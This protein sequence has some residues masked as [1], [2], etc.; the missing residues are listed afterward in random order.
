MDILKVSQWQK[1][2]ENK[3]KK[4]LLALFIVLSPTLASASIF[5]SDAQ[6]VGIRNETGTDNLN[7]LLLATSTIGNGT[8]TILAIAVQQQSA[9]ESTVYCGSNATGTAEAIFDSMISTNTSFQRFMQFKCNKAIYVDNYRTSFLGM[10]YVDRD[11]ATT[12]DPLVLTPQ[13]VTGATST[14]SVG[15]IIATYDGA[16]FQETLFIACVIIF[17]L[18]IL[19]WP[20]FFRM[21][22]RQDPI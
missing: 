9:R 11:T 20:T 15:D 2:D 16:N 3:M 22:R 10:T 13:P 8:R 1:L 7:V 18:A 4:I 17:F 5:P 19:A 14:I 6:T 12:P 21:F